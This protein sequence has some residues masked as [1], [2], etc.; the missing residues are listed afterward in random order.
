M[1][2]QEAIKPEMFHSTDKYSK[3]CIQIQEMNYHVL[4]LDLSYG[5][6]IYE[7]FDCYY[8]TYHL[9]YQVTGQ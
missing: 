2:G 3:S 6:V 5:H 4:N 1:T 9:T 7:A 8:E